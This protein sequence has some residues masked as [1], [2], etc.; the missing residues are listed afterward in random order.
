MNTHL[1][2]TAGR[3]TRLVPAVVAVAAVAASLTLFVTSGGATNSGGPGGH[4]AVPFPA[5]SPR[6]EA[7]RGASDPVNPW[8][9]NNPRYASFVHV[10]V[11]GSVAPSDDLVIPDAERARLL[12]LIEAGVPLTANPTTGSASGTGG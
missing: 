4:S 6:F 9:L 12:A 1:R 7:P 11:G 8:T 10:P 5:A 2:R 3:P